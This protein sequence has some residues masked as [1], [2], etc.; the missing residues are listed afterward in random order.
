MNRISETKRGRR[1]GRRNG[2]AVQ[3]FKGGLEMPERQGFLN[4]GRTGT[5]EGK[6]EPHRTGF[7][8]SIQSDTTGDGTRG[9]HPVKRER[10]SAHGTAEQ[11]TIRGTMIAARKTTGFGKGQ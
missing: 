8:H 3:P 9:I 10:S 4:P 2:T 7:D 6:G 1:P 11:R 5:C